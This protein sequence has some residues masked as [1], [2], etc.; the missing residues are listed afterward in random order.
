ME[1]RITILY[2]VLLL[3]EWIAYFYVAFINIAY[4]YMTY[5]GFSAGWTKYLNNLEKNHFKIKKKHVITH[6][7][8]YQPKI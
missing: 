8:D 3:E 6:K 2:N 7:S 5:S 1:Q 4:I